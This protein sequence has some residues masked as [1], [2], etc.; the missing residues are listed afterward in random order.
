MQVRYQW[1]LSNKTASSIRVWTLVQVTE[2]EFEEINEG[3][4]ACVDETGDGRWQVFMKKEDNY[5][6]KQYST[7]WDA[8]EVVHLILG[9]E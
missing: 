5:R 2:T 4:V 7:C 6:V 8:M 1:T 3:V 9:I